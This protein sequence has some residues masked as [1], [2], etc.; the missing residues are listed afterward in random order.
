LTHR[1]R[2]IRELIHQGEL[3]FF[4]TALWPKF[5]WCGVLT[6]LVGVV[7]KFHRWAV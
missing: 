6:N 7:K 4:F 5:N 2:S 1:G 3:R